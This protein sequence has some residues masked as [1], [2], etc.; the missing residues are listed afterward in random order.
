MS[1]DKDPVSRQNVIDQL[2]RPGHYQDPAL[3]DDME[4]ARARRGE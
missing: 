3:A 4:R 1:L 2:R